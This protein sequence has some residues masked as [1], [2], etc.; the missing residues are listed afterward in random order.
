MA[1]LRVFRNIW[2][3]TGCGT[4]KAERFFFLSFIFLFFVLGHSPSATLAQSGV[5]EN[6]AEGMKAY[7]QGNYQEALD[8]FTKA[9]DSKPDHAQA[10]TNRGLAKYK[11][12]D[13]EGALD[14]H[15][16][17]IKKNPN[18]AAAYTNRGGARFLKGD[19][20][21]AIADH[22]KALELFPEYVQALNNRGFVKLHI[23]DV[24]GATADFDKALTLN[25]FD[26]SAY[27]N[28]A[29]AHLQEARRLKSKGDTEGAQ[30]QLEEAARDAT[31]ALVLNPNLAPTYSLRGR[32]LLEVMALDK[33]LEDFNKAIELDPNLP[34]AYLNRGTIRIVKKDY[35]SGLE[36]IYRALEIAPDLGPV[37]E[38]WIEHA[39]KGL[40]DQA[41]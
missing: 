28:R 39:T 2:M 32:I 23:G 36:D 3:P 16:M 22:T 34:T 5:D 18:F 6:I 40:E 14:D 30:K 8:A 37:A 15:T 20:D 25:P 13:I 33:A 9:I 11:L 41:N 31:K 10:Y 12:G 27:T 17:A 29:S 35:E 21:G 26:P 19:I 7:V 1:L 38:P 24:D 4:R